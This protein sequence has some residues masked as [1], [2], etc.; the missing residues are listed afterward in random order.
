MCIRDSSEIAK[1][2]PKT[3]NLYLAGFFHDIGKGRGGNHSSL[4]E[5]IVKRFCK[6][7][8]FSKED[9]DLI[10]WLVRN[11]LLMSKTLQKEDLSDSLVIKKFSKQV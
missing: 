5:R 4:G 11:H 2:L 1:K 3:I 9:S 8:K 10:Q 6:R 7:N